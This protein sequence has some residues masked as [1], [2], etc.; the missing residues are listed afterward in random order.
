M[1]GLEHVD[2]LLHT[3]AAYPVLPAMD[4][5]P[6]NDEVLH[7]LLADLA[8]GERSRYAE[9]VGHVATEAGITADELAR[10][11]EFL[12]ACLILPR[13]ETYYEMLGVAPTATPAEIRKRWATL[14]QRYHP[15]HFERSDGWVSD[16]ARR[17]IEA[18]QTLRDAERRRRYD[19]V[20]A[21]DRATVTGQRRSEGARHL[22]HRPHP[23]RR[24]WVPPILLVVGLAGVSGVYVWHPP[25]PLPQAALPP[26]PKLID[27]Q[28][29]RELMNPVG[30]PF[31]PRPT[32][33]TEKAPEPDPLPLEQLDPAPEPAPESDWETAH[34]SKNQAPQEMPTV[35]VTQHEPASAAALTSD[36]LTLAEPDGP[37]PDATLI[38]RSKSLLRPA[39]QAPPSA[40][41]PTQLQKERDTAMEPQRSL[42]AEIS[43]VTPKVVSTPPAAVVTIEPDR[44]A[45]RVAPV[46]DDP[47]MLIETFRSTYERKD[48]GALMK[49]FALAP[50]EREAVGQAA[51][52]A[53]Y[54]RNFD[55]LDQIYYQLTELETMAPGSND[56]LVV[57]GWFRIRAIRRDSPSQLVDAAGPVRWLLR[58]EA[59]GLRIAE[60]DYELSRR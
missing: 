5:L 17:L 55:A 11:A 28:Q 38:S 31:S 46:G 3:L 60:I 36:L 15:D 39:V 41:K 35:A 34:G 27:G 2:Q 18:Y 59:N 23:R 20:L 19:A 12:L 13:A 58:R 32:P 52:Q 42:P 43:T 49:L 44:T 6:A 47:L 4:R 25:Q 54:A 57:R 30:F 16:Q 14:I 37:S 45:S 50:R 21:G 7:G 40:T 48:L 22:M 1:I 10:R 9:M 8:G 51:V 56:Y 24:R 53:L 26:A 29:R 33:P